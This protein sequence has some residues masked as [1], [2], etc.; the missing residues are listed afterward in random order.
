[1]FRFK[2]LTFCFNMRKKYIL[3]GLSLFAGAYIY[4]VLMNLWDNVPFP[5]ALFTFRWGRIIFIG[6]FGVIV[7]R[8]LPSR[9]S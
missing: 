9:S 3:F 2:V 5:E 7:A 6:L 1:M 4:E 8:F